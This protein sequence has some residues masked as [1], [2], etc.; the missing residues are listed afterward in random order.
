[1]ED[2]CLIKCVRDTSLWLC[3]T[4]LVASQQQPPCLV[5]P[6]LSYRAALYSRQIN[7]ASSL[8]AV[9][10][11]WLCKGKGR[12][13]AGWVQAGHNGTSTVCLFLKSPA[14]FIAKV[15]KSDRESL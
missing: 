7:Q 6:S 4:P 8:V 11:S 10:Q 1:M 3:P 2:Y 13:Q 5:G 14:R 12:L 15:H 9:S